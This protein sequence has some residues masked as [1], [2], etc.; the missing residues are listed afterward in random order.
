[1]NNH[2]TLFIDESGKASLTHRSNFFVLSAC[3]IEKNKLNEIRNI[4]NN[5]IYK[6]WGTKNSYSRK[7]NCKKILFHA[8]DIAQCK[9]CFVILKDPK[10]NKSFWKDLR[11]QLICRRDITY[12]IAITNKINL[13]KNSPQ[14][15]QETVL[16]KSYKEVLD[17]FITQLI[18][19]KDTGEITA[20][21]TY[22]QDISLVG[23]LNTLQRNSRKIY[24]NSKIANQTITSLSLVNKNDDE[25]GTQIADLIAWTGINKYLVDSGIKKLSDLKIEDQKILKYLNKKIGSK[26]SKKK[27]DKFLIIY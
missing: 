26:N 12:Y 17:S 5:I 9:N 27:F 22:D 2:K 7:F 14:I 6:Y 23:A 21:S 4:A 18:N 10:I 3:S 15:K 19:K 24:G 8:T 20:E 1:M 13:Q 11:T 16:T 25:I